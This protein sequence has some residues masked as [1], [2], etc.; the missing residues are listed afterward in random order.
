MGVDLRQVVAGILT[1]TM[2]VMLGQM[3]HR[4]YFDSLQVRFF[5][6]I[7]CFFS[8]TFFCSNVIQIQLL[9]V[10]SVRLLFFIVTSIF[11]LILL[12]DAF[13]ADLVCSVKFA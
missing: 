8:K 10:C 2:F 4:D 3:L 1:I 6:D 7:F 5:A 11:V 9:Q 12:F 13:E